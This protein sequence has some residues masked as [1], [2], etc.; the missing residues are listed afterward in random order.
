MEIRE[1]VP[2]DAEGIQRVARQAWH[3]VYDR[4][5]GEQGV[6]QMIDEWYGLELLRDS[7][8]TETHPLFVASGDEIVGFAQGGPSED[9]PADA[10]VS[11]IYVLPAHWG[12]GIGT[13]LLSRLFDTFRS[14]GYESVWLSV[15]A[16][17]DIGRSFYDTHGFRIEE[18][19]TTELAGQEIEEIVLVREI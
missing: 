17:N 14:D 16:E 13:A 15:W 5:L 10:V 11:R 19:R 9:G 6:E 7:I 8:E 1:A 18:N 4:R 2:G 3:D 12:E